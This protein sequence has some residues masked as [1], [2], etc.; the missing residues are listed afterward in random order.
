VCAES[1]C[2]ASGSTDRSAQ[3]LCRASGSTDRFAQPLCKASGS[4]GRIAQA[5]C[6][7]TGS[8]RRSPQALCRATCSTHRSAQALCEASGHRSVLA[9]RPRD[10]PDARYEQRN[11]PARGAHA[12]FRE[13]PSVEKMPDGTRET[14]DV[15]SGARSGL[16]PRSRSPP[17]RYEATRGDPPRPVATVATF[18]PWKSNAETKK[19]CLP[20]PQPG[21]PLVDRVSPEVV[22]GRRGSPRIVFWGSP[23]LIG[24]P[25]LRGRWPG[26]RCR[27]RLQRRSG[28]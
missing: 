1:L 6:R 4:T 28:A 2:K 13:G 25:L 19:K 21:P 5:L 11:D 27:P 24:D 22:T 18:D 17:K 26:K 12:L 10:G 20:T 7:A 3:P 15:R 23:T 9:E 14:P 8:T 16:Y